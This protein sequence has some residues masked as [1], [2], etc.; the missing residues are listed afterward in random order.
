MEFEH[1]LIEKLRQAQR[2]VFFTGA[3]VSQESGIPTF[4]DGPSSIWQHFDPMIYATVLGF[5]NNPTQV[6]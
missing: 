6:W 4:R 5:D 2:I 3:G 1:T